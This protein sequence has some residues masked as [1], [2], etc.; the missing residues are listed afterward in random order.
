LPS[1]KLVAESVNGLF[2]RETQNDLCS[3]IPMKDALV[4]INEESAIGCIRKRLEQAIHGHILWY[5]FAHPIHPP[6][7]QVIL[8]TVF[9]ARKQ[10]FAIF[11]LADRYVS[12]LIVTRI[13]P[14]DYQN[15][16]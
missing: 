10:I 4:S 5:V 12:A 13:H 8:K 2:S 16:S 11:V 7:G 9:E 6:D 3:L 1:Q 14:R 15:L